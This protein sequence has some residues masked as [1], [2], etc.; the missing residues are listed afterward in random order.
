MTE[1][2][3]TGWGKQGANEAG[4]FAVQS[5]DLKTTAA[6]FRIRTGLS[7]RETWTV[8]YLFYDLITTAAASLLQSNQTGQHSNRP[9]AVIEQE[10]YDF[11]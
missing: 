11:P 4:G 10:A 1:L 7:S 9:R 3:R 6:Q 2:L 8:F 5:M